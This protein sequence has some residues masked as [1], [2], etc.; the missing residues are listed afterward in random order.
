MAA[1]L[2]FDEES[3]SSDEGDFSFS[4]PPSLAPAPSA[5]AASP[6]A[7]PAPA[8]VS[9]QLA[10]AAAPMF[11]FSDDSDDDAPI[12][13]MAGGRA[14]PASSGTQPNTVHTALPSPSGGGTM[15]FNLSASSDDDIAAV[16]L[17]M[18][19]ASEATAAG[20]RTD[21]KPQQGTVSKAKAALFNGDPHAVAV[22][23]A[24]T[25]PPPTPPQQQVRAVGT[26]YSCC[27]CISESHRCG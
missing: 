6:A 13:M 26:L 21:S 23:A 24:P 20:R 16:P 4:A 22:A 8:P 25:A 10:A 3:E 14:S 27:P 19:A 9:V 18:G 17:S 11:S 12:E 2:D 15:D 7:A 5:S 1:A